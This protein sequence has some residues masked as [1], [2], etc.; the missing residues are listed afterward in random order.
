MNLVRVLK[1]LV[2]SLKSR[3]P[4]IEKPLVLSAAQ[5]GERQRS[6]LSFDTGY[7]AE[8]HCI[9]TPSYL[10]PNSGSLQKPIEG[11]IL[12]LK[13]VEDRSAIGGFRNQKHAEKN[14]CAPSKNAKPER[15]LISL[16]LCLFFPVKKTCAIVQNAAEKCNTP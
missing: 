7:S 1:G 5:G 4:L 9:G 8:A 16:N 14:P 12:L 2:V 3:M 11:S 13:N 6:S 10:E 15:R